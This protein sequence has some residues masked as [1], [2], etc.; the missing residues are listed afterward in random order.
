MVAIIIV[1]WNNSKDIVACLTSLSKLEYSD[2]K[3]IVVDNSSSDGTLDLVRSQFPGVDAVSTGDNLFFAGGNNFG[4]KYAQEKYHPDYFAILNPDTLVQPNWLSAQVEV[5]ESDL[6]IGIVGPKVIF[7]EGFG[8][9][10]SESADVAS[11]NK[12]IINTAGIL[13]GG[14]LFPYDRGFNE[15]DKG[16]YDQTEEVYAL[17]GVSMLLRKEVF[18]QTGG[19][20]A[21]MQM[22]LEDVDLCLQAKKQGWKVVYTPNTTVEHKHMQ[23]TSQTSKERYEFWSKRNYLLLVS[24]NYSF[25]KFLRALLEVAQSTS[26]ILTLRVLGSFGVRRFG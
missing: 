11:N 22:Y 17:S 20:Y 24:R 7:A 18:T 15:I 1:T 8:P 26:L 10:P 21:P 19:F 3:I 9:K 2:F 16:Q 25:K 6:K 4:M 5:L 13:P 23:S 12:R 14:F